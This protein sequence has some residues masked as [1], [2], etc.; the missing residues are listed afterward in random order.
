MMKYCLT[1]ILVVFS[2][3]QAVALRE[4][5][6]SFDEPLEK[7][8]A[9]L[10]QDCQRFLKRMKDFDVRAEMKTGGYLLQ[11]A[12]IQSFEQA[13]K[14]LAKFLPDPVE[15]NLV[16]YMALRFGGQY[17]KPSL[18]SAA[19]FVQGFVRYFDRDHKQDLLHMEKDKFLLV[20][21]ALSSGAMRIDDEA[22]KSAV[23]MVNVDPEN[24]KNEFV[25]QEL[26]LTK[27]GEALRTVFGKM[28]QRIKELTPVLQSLP[29]ADLNSIFEA[30][31]R[32]KTFLSRNA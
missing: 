23:K 27:E 10:R 31:T 4:S 16:L 2:L 5:A 11:G 18:E 29:D 17:F 22:I 14:N 12:D 21:A 13:S 8:Y 26:L 6:S 25:P 19:D 30:L 28:G 24:F 15:K 7:N 9:A 32:F 3:Q 20:A 1:L